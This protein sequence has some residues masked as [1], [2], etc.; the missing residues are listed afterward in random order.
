MG[1]KS[2]VLVNISENPYSG[3]LD[4]E[5]VKAFHKKYSGHWD[6]GA[7]DCGFPDKF[8]YET[9]KA[10]LWQYKFSLA[11]VSKNVIKSSIIIIQPVWSD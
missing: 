10:Y 5:S 6:K 1:K 4:D 9:V 7:D 2:G 3:L 8:V 11:A